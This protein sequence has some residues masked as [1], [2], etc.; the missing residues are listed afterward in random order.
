MKVALQVL[1]KALVNMPKAHFSLLKGVLPCNLVGPL[2]CGDWI[3]GL[4]PLATSRGGG[5]GGEVA[6]SAGVV[7]VP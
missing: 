2:L 5:A 7:S 4:F 6:W 1:L 3:P